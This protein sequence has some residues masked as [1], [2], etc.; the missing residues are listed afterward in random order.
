[1]KEEDLV[2]QVL[3]IAVPHLANISITKKKKALW[4]NGEQTSAVSYT[5]EHKALNVEMCSFGLC[6]VGVNTVVFYHT[7]VLFAWAPGSLGLVT[8]GI[9]RHISIIF[10]AFFSYFLGLFRATL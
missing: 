7:I 2:P 9:Y 3:T 6:H 5:F 8:P 10:L 1:M 4:I